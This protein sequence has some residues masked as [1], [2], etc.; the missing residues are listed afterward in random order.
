MMF[1]KILAAAFLFLTPLFGLALVKL[2]GLERF[3]INFADLALPVLMFEIVMVSQKF[4][5]H[6]Y[7]PHYLIV[8]ALVA[9]GVVYWLFRKDGE[10]F[11][12]RR[13]FKFFW[14]LS[15]IFSFFFYLAVVIAVFVF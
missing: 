6:S 4:F 7:L 11:S 15:F 3:K 10:H 9:I 2:F 12:Y 1:Y 8:L 5:V 13:F 14:R